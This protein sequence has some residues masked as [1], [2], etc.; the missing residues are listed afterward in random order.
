MHCTGECT[1]WFLLRFGLPVNFQPILIVPDKKGE[2][3]LL[4]V[5]HRL[6]SYLD[7]TADPTGVDVRYT[8]YLIKL[9]SFHSDI[10]YIFSNFLSHLIDSFFCAYVYLHCTV[11]LL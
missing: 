4:S 3:Q 8:L 10:L 5:L 7:S 9:Y 1:C 2:K 11:L 6:F